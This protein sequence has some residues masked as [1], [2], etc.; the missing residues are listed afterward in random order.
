MFLHFGYLILC[1]ILR[2]AVQGMRGEWSKDI[3]I[4]VLRH[5]V[6][7]L[8]PAGGTPGPGAHRPGGAVS[9]VTAAAPLTVVDV[10]RHSRHGAALA[11]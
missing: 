1:Q 3:E 5:Q 8:R 7:V 4:L 10:L 9:P 11:P 2:L 6:A